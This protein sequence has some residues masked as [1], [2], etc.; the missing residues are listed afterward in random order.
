MKK[1]KKVAKKK[2]PARKPAVRSQELVVRVI[3]QPD[4]L[5]TVSD[6]TE[7]IHEGKQLAIPKTWVSE[8]QIMRM[9]QKTPPQHIYK[10]PGKGGGVWE[11]VTGAYVEKVLNF[12]FGFLWDFEII[13]HG[14]EEGMV[15]VKGKLTVRDAKGGAIVKMQFGRA[16][17]KYKKDTKIMLDYGNDLK[18]ASTDALK[19]C[20]SLLGI[21]SDIYGKSEY[22]QETNRDP[23]P[24]PVKQSVEKTIEILKD[25][26]AH[27]DYHCEGP[28]GKG[29]SYGSISISE[30]EADYS[31]KMFGKKLCRDCQKDS[32]PLKK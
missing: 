24:A 22:K 30:Q 6:I 7:P 10:R 12:V 3:P 18:S 32:K 1:K 4:V 15:W 25:R 2:A 20:A 23:A 8:K 5:P 19:K 11:Y 17:I 26:D 14:K 13:E 27:V 31:K 9:V 29:C 16:D 21:A 28:D